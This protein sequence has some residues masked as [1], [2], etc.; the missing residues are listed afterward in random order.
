MNITG[1]SLADARKACD[2][3]AQ[4]TLPELFIERSRESPDVVALRYKERGLYVE[5]SWRRYLDRVM[6]TAAGLAG[7]GVV[8]GARVAL[9]GDPSIEYLLGHLGTIFAAAIPYGIYPTSSKNE[10]AFQLRRGGARIIVAGDQEHLDKLL[11]AENFA[12]HP[13]VDRVVLIDC[14]TRFL[15]D[16]PR[17]V[18]FD[19]LESEGAASE[20][21]R[22]IVKERM[23]A[24]T[25]ASPAGLIFTSGTTGDAKGALYTHGGLLVGL[26][27]CL[28]EAMPE[29]RA[30]P[31]RVVTHLPLAHGLGQGLAILI[32]LFA[33]VVQHIAERGQS[34]ASLLTEVRPTH[35]LGVPRVWQKMAAQVCIGVDISGPLRR[36]LF[37][38]A[39][40]VGRK[41]VR[42][43]WANRRRRAGPMLEALYWVAY[44]ALIWPAL[45]KLGMAHA[46]GG[47]TGGAP[48]PEGVQE[49]WQAWG[50]PLHNFFGTTEAGVNAVQC[51]PW[52]RPADP[53][54]PCYPKQV[55]AAPDSEIVV[56]GPGLFAGY[57]EDPEAS[58]STFDQEGRVLTGDIGQ[59]DER[60][61]FL[62]VDR[63]KDILVTSG[64]KNVAPAAVEN[65]L[66]ASPYISEAIVFG[67]D[68]K[69]ITALIE[70]DFDTV[71]SWAR[72]NGV[73]YTS[74][75]TLVE[76]ERVMKLIAVQVE[77]ANGF[78]ARPEQVKYFRIIPKELDPEE[79]DTTPTRKVKRLHAYKMFQHLV[80]DMYRAA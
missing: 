25:S 78:L 32:P 68:R 2:R 46:I 20:G 77:S 57:W 75:R 59:F 72:E 56:G 13:L 38:W 14:R 76:D 79:G 19:D 49:R 6:A 10:V 51:A 50:L 8:P 42:A 74:F 18:A 11:A 54:E 12:G 37:V 9:M 60:G 63:K 69:F 65:A 41:R 53:L 47:S 52:P 48:V 70:V 16:D 23:E 39:E 3:L 26:G 17:I 62:I 7:L 55:T 21:A 45:Y 15:Y 24:L 44:R 66:K 43:L 30:R 27:Y 31:H 4:A 22:R 40:G 1:M 34:F 36:A 80:E 71:S 67:D 73:V 64:G 33:D 35:L 29:L 58:A 61:A 5:L 28:F